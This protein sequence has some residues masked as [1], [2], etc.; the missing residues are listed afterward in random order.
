M[1]ARVRVRVRVRMRV[2]VR[3]KARVEVGV[4]VRVQG[5]A[6]LLDRSSRCRAVQPRS[7]SRPPSSWLGL[8]LRGL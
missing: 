2:R 5:S 4:G 8:G 3:A 7:G 1:R 6:W